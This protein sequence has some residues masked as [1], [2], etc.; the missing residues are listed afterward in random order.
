[1][2][3]PTT[4]APPRPI[5]A[6]VA[7]LAETADVPALAGLHGEHAHWQWDAHGLTVRVFQEPDPLGFLQACA[8]R[9]SST[10]RSTAIMLTGDAVLFEVAAAVDGVRVSICAPIGGRSAEARLRRRVAELEERLG[11]LPATP[12]QL[13]EQRHMLEAPA[14]PPP[15]VYVPPLDEWCTGCN[16]DHAPAECGYRPAAEST[17]AGGGR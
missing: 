17:P 3:N 5:A 8:E 6:L 7:L 1:M 9:Y 14:V 10:V 13:A 12:G 11:G 15:A 16:A 2:T 4:P